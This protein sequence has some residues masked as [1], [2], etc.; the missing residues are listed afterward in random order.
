MS[1]EEGL[2]FLVMRVCDFLAEETARSPPRALSRCRARDVPSP[3][4]IYY[5]FERDTSFRF[6]G[7]RAAAATAD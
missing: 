2:R 3:L 4:I 6:H 7:H 1:F 5:L